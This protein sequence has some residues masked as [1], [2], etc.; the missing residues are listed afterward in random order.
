MLAKMSGLTEPNLTRHG[1]GEGG[2]TLASNWLFFNLS[3]S[4]IVFDKTDS[5][6][7]RMPHATRGPATPPDAAH[8]RG[9]V[10]RIRSLRGIYRVASKS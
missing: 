3:A 8:C 10:L 7:P 9:D 4:K 1:D 5:E 6:L 2:V